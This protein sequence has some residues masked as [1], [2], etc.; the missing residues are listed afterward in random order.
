MLG[1]YVGVSVK[2][3]CMDMDGFMKVLCCDR[4]LDCVFRSSSSACMYG[5]KMMWG[6]IR[7]INTC[8]TKKNILLQLWTI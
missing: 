3:G 6:M 4:A 2:N 5:I 1:R 7:C 8:K